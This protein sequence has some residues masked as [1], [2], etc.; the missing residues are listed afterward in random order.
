MDTMQNLLIVLLVLLNFRL[1]GSSR[2]AVCIQTIAMQAVVLGCVSLLANPEPG[3]RIVIMFTT[4][5]VIKAALLPW[6]MHRAAREAKGERELE[7]YIGYSLS[8]MIGAIL[9]I[10]C[11][12]IARPFRLPTTA[13]SGALVPVALF[14]MLTGLLLIVSRRTAINQ[15]LGYLSME[16]GIYAIGMALAIEEPFLIEMGVLLDV[17]VAIF[18]MGIIIY[19]ISREFDHINVD[20]LSSLKD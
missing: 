13:I 7:P 11:F 1:L 20:Q 15:V 19:R 17:F 10:L 8:L 6:L 2:I 14:T 12:H 5:T 16:N 3:L 4:I 9:L 18:V